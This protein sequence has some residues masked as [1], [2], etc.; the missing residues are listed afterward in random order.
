MEGPRKRDYRQRA[1]CNPLSDTLMSSPTSPDCVDWS[2]HFPSFF[3]R[4]ED[5]TLRLNT[6]DHPI[7]YGEICDDAVNG[8][9]GPRPEIL[10]VGCGFGGLL[11][12]LSPQFPST[13]ILGLEIREKVAT[14]V[15]RRIQTLRQTQPGEF[16]NVSVVRTNT[17]KFLAKYIRKAQLTKMFFC[18]PDPHVKRSNWRRRIINPSL[19]SQYAFF[20][21][22]GGM[23]YTITDVHDLH[24]WM[25]NCCT[26]HP[27]FERV[28]A[29]ELVNDEAFQAIHSVTE[30]GQKV[31]RN[32]QAMHAAVF[33]RIS[34][35]SP[36]TA[37]GNCINITQ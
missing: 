22:D 17:M 13:L 27:L 18:F 34:E 6:F 4:E 32:Q 1:H 15:G 7:E 11:A 25:S 33:R 16:C 29:D 23:L 19:L 28:H 2:V 10:D 36:P 3:N 24:L 9:I 30:E 12:A 20:L 37:T 26:E 31:S 35:C 8:R 5:T 14:Y 21:R